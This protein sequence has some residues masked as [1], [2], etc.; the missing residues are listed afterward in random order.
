M[1]TVKIVDPLTLYGREAIHLLEQSGTLAT[2][3]S[4]CHTAEDDEHQIA[5]VGGEPGLVPPLDDAGQLAD[6]DALLITGSCES[7]RGAI[8]QEFVDANPSTLVVSLGPSSGLV[9]L[10]VPA[11]G[12]PPDPT[13]RHLRV[14]HPALVV[15]S[16][17]RD[18]LRHFEPESATVAAVD[19]VSVSGRDPVEQLARQ[20][21]QRLQ[22]SEVTELID[23]QVLAFTAVAGHDDDLNR[24]AASLHP[25]LPVA[26][27]RTYA[28]RFHGNVA[29]IGL[30]FAQPGSEHEIREAIRDDPRFAEPNLPLLLD[31][32]TDSD[33]IALSLPR[34]SANDRV[35]AITAMVDGLRVGGALTGIEILRS[36]LMQR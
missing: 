26:A 27:T 18:C 13:E 1:A 30:E 10:L 4:Y 9:D 31:A 19:P 21:A 20:A 2:S 8:V 24:D 7:P 22:G 17:L 23:G 5:E 14:A 33:H 6:A 34:M 11:A 3:L 35:L 12:P 32:S 15:L 16:Q 25:D 36:M 28:G 29:H